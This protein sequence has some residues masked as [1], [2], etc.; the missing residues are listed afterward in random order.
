M[1]Q[2]RLMTGLLHLIH[3]PV[4]VP[5]CLHRDGA[6]GRQASQKC[7]IQFPIMIHSHCGF[8]LS[9]LI[10]SDKQRIFL[11]R[12]TTDKMS[13]AATP[14]MVFTDRGIWYP[15]SV[16]QRFHPIKLAVVEDIGPVALSPKA[17]SS[18]EI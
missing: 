8:C 16:L 13:H 6:A 2:A 7:P 11:V 18:I 9:C 14:P 15:P 4:P 12:I 10:H 5:D 17:L 3:D 1:G